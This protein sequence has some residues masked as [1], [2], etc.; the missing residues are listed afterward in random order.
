MQ[1]KNSKRKVFGNIILPQEM[2]KISNKQPKLTLK[3]LEEVEQT[4]HK[5]TRRKE[6]TDKKINEA[7]SW[8]FGKINKIG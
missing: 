3:Q 4:K 7:K 2:R 6:I 1:Q 5:V 8:F